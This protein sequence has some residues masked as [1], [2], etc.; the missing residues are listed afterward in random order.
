MNLKPEISIFPFQLNGGG[1]VISGCIG[2]SIVSEGNTPYVWGELGNSWSYSK[3]VVFV[4]SQNLIVD[5]EII[6]KM[7]IRARKADTRNLRQK[8]RLRGRFESA[9]GAFGAVIA[10]VPI[11]E[12]CGKIIP[13]ELNIGVSSIFQLIA[14]ALRVAVTSAEEGLFSGFLAIMRL[15]KSTSEG[16]DSVSSVA[17]S[18][19]GSFI[20]FWRISSIFLPV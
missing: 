1:F 20:C 12:S 15:T 17:R 5:N 8:S 6:I 18:G 16:E 13:D 19:T 10:G 11:L 9:A 4:G 3:N 7:K 14:S 2:V